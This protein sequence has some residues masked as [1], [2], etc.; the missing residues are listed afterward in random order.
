MFDKIIFIPNGFKYTNSLKNKIIKSLLQFTGVP[1]ILL[2]LNNLQN[3][4][5]LKAINNNDLKLKIQELS[6]YSK[7]RFFNEAIEILILIFNN[8]KTSKLLSKFIAFQFQVMKRHNTFLTFLKRAIFVFGNIK[9]ATIQGVKIVIN[10]RFNGVP[11]AGGR[12]IQNGRL[13]LQ[14][15]NS[16]INYHNTEA[17]TPYGTFGIKVWICE[18]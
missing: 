9:L 4:S 18:K 5:I 14:T 13:P 15:I 10:G 6:I 11:R 16:K 8:K 3:S 7:E 17:Q 12:I 1:K 2:N